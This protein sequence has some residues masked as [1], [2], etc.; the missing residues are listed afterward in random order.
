MPT[1]PQA[2][3][4]LLLHA[5]Y[6]FK[7]DSARRPAWVN[8][9]DMAPLLGWKIQATAVMLRR[10]EMQAYL[11]L[12]AERDY[13]T[14]MDP[15]E[16]RYGLTSEGARRAAAYTDPMRLGYTELQGQVLVTMHVKET[17][18][19]QAQSNA[20]ELQSIFHEEVLADLL[21]VLRS[22]ESQGYLEPAAA[23]S[24]DAES[25]LYR[26][27]QTGHQVADYYHR[28]GRFPPFTGTATRPSNG[29]TYNMYGSNSRVNNHS[30]DSSTNTVTFQTGIDAAT[31]VQAI[32][33]VRTALERLEDLDERE[34]G[35][36]RLTQ[37]Q[38]TV[39]A[40]QPADGQWRKLVA[41]GAALPAAISGTAVVWNA[42]ATLSGAAGHPLPEAPQGLGQ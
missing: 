17:R 21:R 2:D 39:E 1:S 4:S 20:S 38:R 13:D 28:E 25:D 9:H 19:G 18:D 29:D 42:L 16:Q 15:L 10:L 36:L 23:S 11:A 14:S 34:M 12:A 26:V 30:T 6:A 7:A 41:W 22:L 31:F 3:E 8:A 32:T 33:A 27:T 5:V 40:A 24:G 35:E 37:F